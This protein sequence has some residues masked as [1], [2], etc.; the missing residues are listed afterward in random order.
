MDHLNAQ[1]PRMNAHLFDQLMNNGVVAE[2]VLHL[3]VQDESVGETFE[4]ACVIAPKL[5]DALIGESTQTTLDLYLDY[6]VPFVVVNLSNDLGEKLNHVLVLLD[7]LQEIHVL[8]DS[9]S[10]HRSFLVSR[11][12]IE[13]EDEDRFDFFQIFVDE[14]E[15]FAL[16]LTWLAQ[17]IPA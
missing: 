10:Q 3:N 2:Q 4:M 1:S 6:D 16:N 14:P 12:D 13:K 17:R 8:L 11:N 9:I 7:D 15:L 5:T